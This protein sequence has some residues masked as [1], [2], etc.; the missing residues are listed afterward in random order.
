MTDETST[1]TQE[2]ICAA[3]HTLTSAVG[4][5]LVT[6]D[7]AVQMDLGTKVNLQTSLHNIALVFENFG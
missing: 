4:T 5:M 3:I 2:Q 6:H 1:P 7:S